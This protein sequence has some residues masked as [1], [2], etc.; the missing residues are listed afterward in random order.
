MTQ[1]SSV[2]WTVALLWMLASPVW[3]V[4]YRLQVVNL[5]YLTVS[6]YNA[7]PS[8]VF[9]GKENLSSLEARLD[10]M[11]FP[12]GAIIPGREV[13]LLED[14][15]Y[16]GKVPARLSVLPATRDQAWTTLVWDADPGDTMAFI[17][18]SDMVAWQEAW[19]IAA[20]PEGTLRQLSIGG[21]SL[22]GHW[23]YEVPQVSYD[24]I[25]NAVGQRTFP[26]WLEHTVKSLNGMSV[27]IG[28]GRSLFY[29]PDR[30]Y[31]VLKLPAES[32]T[33]KV[34]IGWRDH[35]DRGTGSR[36]RFGLLFP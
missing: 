18:K 32:R 29:N 16:G 5:D 8:A 12:T 19:M 9:G 22:F 2:A 25:A 23:S 24:F 1:R 14:P 11:E 10:K 3:A 17:V 13:Q 4:E 28:R 35:S 6:A 27:V 30:V 31:V 33:Y 36:E 7:K 15:G 34:V 21:P 20:N 26:S